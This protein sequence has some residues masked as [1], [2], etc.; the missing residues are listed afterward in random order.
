MEKFE[1]IEDLGSEIQDVCQRLKT[2]TL[3]REELENFVEKSRALYERSLVLRYKMYE[4]KVFGAI[5]KES[6]PENNIVEE[7]V[8][9]SHQL[10]QENESSEDQPLFS[11]NLFDEE[12]KEESFNNEKDSI[13]ID[14]IEESA[15]IEI[16]EEFHSENVEITPPVYEA[17]KVE[18]VNQET[19]TITVA[20]NAKLNQLFVRTYNEMKGQ[21]GITRLETLVGSFGLNER[22]LFINELF[23]GSAESFSEAIKSIDSKVELDQT[24][25]FINQLGTSNQWDLESDTVE[26]F[27]Q[28]VVRRHV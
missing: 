22:L 3:T 20:E 26:E 2:E 27:L 1:S 24:K 17:P 4:E 13:E 12:S 15:A 5:E 23:D 7:A 9:E 19:E 28:K 25:S 18:P 6:I 14:E 10:D 8:H 16:E 11:F 21:V